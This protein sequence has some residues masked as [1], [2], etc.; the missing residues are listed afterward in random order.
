MEK[1]INFIPGGIPS[2]DLPETTELDLG[3]QP[4]SDASQST[5]PTTTTAYQQPATEVTHQPVPTTTYSPPAVEAT[6]TNPKPVI[7]TTYPRPVSVNPY[8]TS[9]VPY[10][11]SYAKPYTNPYTNP[12]VKPVQHSKA[13]GWWN[14]VL[15]TGQTYVAPKP[16]APVQV[17]L[18]FDSVKKEATTQPKKRE[19]IA[20]CKVGADHLA[21]RRNNQDY[22]VV[23][24]D[25][26]L[27]VVLDGCGSHNN[28][29]V[30][31]KLF[32]QI[33][34]TKKGVTSEN[35]KSVVD[36][37]FL[38]LAVLLGTDE[39]ILETLSFTILACFEEE[40]QYVVLTC[41]DGYIIADNGNA[42]E[43]IDLDERHDNAP[44]YYVCNCVSNPEI[45]A[46]NQEGVDF[47]KR[48]FD[49]KSY[50]NVGLATDG[51]RFIKKLSTTDRYKLMINLVEGNQA[52][53]AALL[54]RMSETFKD[55]ITICY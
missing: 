37:I 18:A 36:E 13:K 12:Y 42:V 10:G 27:K 46:R 33:L 44:D 26:K 49:K 51:L 19:P 35:F 23:M 24:N 40:E 38:N 52:Q 25:G 8:A 54:N 31:A 4:E 34:E 2:N 20:I 11:N 50:L 41:G 22:F 47:S 5:E 16:A 17:S 7:G 45:L 32:S 9:A 43:L 6:A 3:I 28:S 21:E 55:D 14:H 53:V 15:G 30:G 29:E 39:M 48:V 1:D